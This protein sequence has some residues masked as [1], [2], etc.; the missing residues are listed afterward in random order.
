MFEVN[1][2]PE[3]KHD[4]IKALRMRNLIL[5]ICIAASAISVAI[6]LILLSIKGGQ[7]IAMSSQDS[8]TATLSEKLNQFNDLSE[9]LT[10]QDQLENLNA[11]ANNKVAISRI[12]GLLVVLQDRG[13][14][15][16]SFSSIDYSAEDF[17]LTI[18]GQVNANTQPNIDYRVLEEFKKNAGLITYDYG[19]YVDPRG[20]VIPSYCISD[21]NANGD[22]YYSNHYSAYYA[23]WN[24]MEEGCNPSD[25]SRTDIL[26]YNL[27]PDTGANPNV[28]TEETNEEAENTTEDSEEETTD[29][30]ENSDDE[31]TVVDDGTT[32]EIV[33]FRTPLFEQW[34]DSGNMNASG[35][36][37][38]MPHFESNC[39]TYSSAQDSEG[40]LVWS[41]S[42]S[43]L[44]I[45]DGMEITD[46]SNG[47]DESDNLVLRFSAE[48]IVDDAMLDY[49]NQF[50]LWRNPS[51][52]NVTDSFLQIADMFA[53]RAEDC[54]ED[55]ETCNSTTNSG[56]SEVEE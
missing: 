30:S 45:P 54:A 22:H 46:S 50:M 8:K 51:G 31:G 9:M 25:L 12:F 24:F 42:N 56:E 19:D 41:E 40:N 11:I 47:T 20:E 1:L 5:F 14:D 52:A 13:A 34:V 23:Y 10:I 36:I 2:V 28:E 6:V 17:S 55:D 16:V 15:D 29:E 38:N 43:C 26:S 39:T 48:I 21:T 3:L 7:D 27:N 44:A 37:T 32:N 53:K 18:E 35:E 49:N 33:I 4:A